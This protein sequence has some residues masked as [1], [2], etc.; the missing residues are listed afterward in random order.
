MKTF[1]KIF[2]L[3]KKQSIWYDDGM[4]KWFKKADGKDSLSTRVYIYAVHKYILGIQPLK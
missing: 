2:S 3:A 4:I 1:I